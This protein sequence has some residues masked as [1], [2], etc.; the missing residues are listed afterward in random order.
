M[1][2]RAGWD[3]S[4]RL[5]PL[6]FREGFQRLMVAGNRSGLPVS[7]WNFPRPIPGLGGTGGSLGVRAGGARS[8]PVLSPCGRQSGA[9]PCG[10]PALDDCQSST[11]QLLQPELPQSVMPQRAETRGGFS[12]LPRTT[13]AEPATRAELV[14]D[15]WRTNWAAA[16]NWTS[17]LARSSSLT[18][19]DPCAH[20]ALLTSQFSA[21]SPRLL[22]THAL[23]PTPSLIEVS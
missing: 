19:P 23:A 9:L 5:I 21:P 6:W 3:R 10:T 1:R 12:R 11:A 20:S 15:L 4:C 17:Q 7:R 14:G 8:L 22:N 18:M 13:H 16:G 2:L